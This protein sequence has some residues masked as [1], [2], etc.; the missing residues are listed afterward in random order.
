MA[1]NLQNMMS[2]GAVHQGAAPGIVAQLAQ[3]SP[4]T[5]EVNIPI[6]D[7]YPDPE[8]RNT[9]SIEDI[10]ELAASI[11]INGLLH[12]I[13][14]AA[15]KAGKYMIISG[16]RRWTACKYLVEQGNS[17]FS[18]IRAMV[19]YEENENLRKLQWL[20]ANATARRL[21]DA[22]LMSQAMITW[23]LLT[24]LKQEGALKG[25]IR[26][27]VGKLLNMSNTQLARYRQID[28]NL[29]PELKAQFEADKLPISTAEKASKLDAPKQREIAERIESGEHVSLQEVGE[30]AKEPVKKKEPAP[31]TTSRYSEIDSKMA[32]AAFAIKEF[33]DDNHHNCARCLFYAN[34]E[35]RIRRPQDW[36]I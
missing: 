31:K 25:N 19:S 11:Q 35:C 3:A 30:M 26:E 15:P 12:N 27:Q 14:V 1:F 23:N 36:N 7:I 10:E 16:E 17:E 33:C 18:T 6:E 28:R 29:E 13:V 2:R 24:K 4:R 34:D 5:Q 8:N 21:T 32:K 9:Y 20:M 22:E